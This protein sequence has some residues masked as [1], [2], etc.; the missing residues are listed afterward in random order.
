[1]TIEERIDELEPDAAKRELTDFLKYYT[2]P[3]FG[4][5]PKREIDL[6][7]FEMMRNLGLVRDDATTYS[8]M[9]EL[10]VTHSKA[11]QLLFDH[12][13]R[14]RGGNSEEL[15]KGVKEAIGSLNFIKDGSWVALEIENPLILAHLKD[16][17]RRTGHITD[18]SFSP[19][20]VR[21]SVEALTGV[22]SNFW[23]KKDKTKIEKHLVSI[24]AKRDQSWKGILRD[25]IVH[26]GKKAIGDAADSIWD[27]ASET[28]KPLCDGTADKVIE[29][30]KSN[31]PDTDTRK[32]K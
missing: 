24:G 21:L 7:I 11:R 15:D 18:G 29:F 14:K 8:L 1:M 9:T 6:R 26:V 30:V 3:A 16:I 20:I 25:S 13:V 4:S 22:M 28:F 5:F 19:S 2:K 31:L 23:S 12:D 27:N 32:T 10:R 17:V